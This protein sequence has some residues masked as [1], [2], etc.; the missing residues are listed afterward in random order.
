MLHTCHLAKHEVKL[1]Q[2]PKRVVVLVLR[3][4]VDAE[5]MALTVL[6]FL[7]MRNDLELKSN[8]LK[9]TFTIVTVAF[10]IF[11]A[12]ASCLMRYFLRLSANCSIEIHS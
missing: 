3:R 8:R 9:L 11:S 1:L 6:T 12:I 2:D 10:G 4:Q 5:G 7:G